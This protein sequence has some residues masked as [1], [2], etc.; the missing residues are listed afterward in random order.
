MTRLNPNSDKDLHMTQPSSSVWRTLW[1]L[2]MWWMIPM[3]LIALLF[4]VLVV[5]SD[6]TGDSPFIYTIF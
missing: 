5:F 4:I 3:G 6:A 1:E 2:K